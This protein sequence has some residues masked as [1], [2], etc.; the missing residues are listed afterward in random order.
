MPIYIGGLST[1]SNIQPLC[2][3]CN[4]NK[5]LDIVDYRPQAMKQCGIC[6]LRKQY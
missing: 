6:P 1:V 3:A 2:A 5:G 4:R